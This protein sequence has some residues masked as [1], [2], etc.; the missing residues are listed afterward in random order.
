MTGGASEVQ[1]T[2]VELQLGAEGGESEVQRTS[3]EQQLGAERA[4]RV[5]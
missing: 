5:G 2:S 1:R 3:V 4:L